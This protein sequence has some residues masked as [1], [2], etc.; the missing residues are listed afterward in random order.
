MLRPVKVAGALLPHVA[1]GENP[2]GPIAGALV[3]IGSL[4]S[5][6]RVLVKALKVIGV[7]ID[8][9]LASVSHELREFWSMNVSVS[10]KELRELA[11]SPLDCLT[12]GLLETIYVKRAPCLVEARTVAI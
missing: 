12:E 11:A 9:A 5:P 3:G 6:C 7:R 8:V 4:C 1:R 2:A 10:E